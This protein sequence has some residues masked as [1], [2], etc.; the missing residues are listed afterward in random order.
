VCAPNQENLKQALFEW[1]A[2]HWDLDMFTLIALFLHHQGSRSKISETRREVSQ[3]NV[4]SSHGILVRNFEFKSSF[5]FGCLLRLYAWLLSLIERLHLEA[6]M[7]NISTRICQTGKLRKS[8]GD[9]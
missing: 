9:K 6:C 4:H 7:I 1:I 3:N 5:E 2:E 8:D